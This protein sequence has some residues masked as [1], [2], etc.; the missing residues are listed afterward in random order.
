MASPSDGG[1]TDTPYR[2]LLACPA[3]LSRSQLFVDF[4][5]RHD[6]KPHSN[7]K[8]EESIDEVWK[9]GMLANP[10]L[11]NAMKFRYGG[12]MTLFREGSLQETPNCLCLGLT[13]YRMFI[14]TNLSPSWEQ[15]IVAI[16]DDVEQCKHTSSPLGNGAI[17]ETIDNF[18][19]VLE[20]SHNVGEFPGHLV[21]PGGHSEPEELGISGHVYDDDKTFKDNLNSMISQEM[22]DGIIREVE[23]EIGVSAMS[24]SDPIFIGISRR[25]MNVR[26]AA[27]FYIKCSLSSSDILRLYSKARDGFESTQLC[28][29][30]KSELATAASKMPGCH[31]GGFALYDLMLKRE[32]LSD[33]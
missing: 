32:Q 30:P 8:L 18:I 10:S 19:L 7:L 20:R 1:T 25:V 28:I 4:D 11:Y 26:P 27:F 21:F 22:F 31:Q 13:D 23:E 16:E 14:G 33:V 6:R 17:V 15:Y 12:C 29:V 2:L 24:L 3:G 5:P 9:Q